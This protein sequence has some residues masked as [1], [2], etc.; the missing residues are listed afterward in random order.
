MK[1]EHAA[2]GYPFPYLFDATQSVAKAYQAACTPDFF[3][4]DSKFFIWSIAG[5]LTTA[6]PK[7]AFR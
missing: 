1:A 3:L 2:A 4:F 5:S 6:A 7:P